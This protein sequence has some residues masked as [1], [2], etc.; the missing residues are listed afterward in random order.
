[1]VSS[2][3]YIGQTGLRAGQTGVRVASENISNV[4]TPGYHRRTPIFEPGRTNPYGDLRLGSGVR[5]VESRRVVEEALDRRVRSTIG[6][7]AASS[8]RSDVLNRANVFLGDLENAGVSVA[9]DDFFASLDLLAASPEDRVSRSN[10]IAAAQ[11]LTESVND[12]GRNL[13]VMRS[14]VDPEL[15]STVDRV[16]QLAGEIAELNRRIG[17]D[18]RISNDVLD[19]RAG[20][21]DELSTLVGTTVTP[22]RSGMW[23]VSLE[24]GYTLV[25]GDQAQPLS[26]LR[27]PD[28]FIQIEGRDAG[29]VRPLTER[30]RQGRVGGL[31]SARDDDLLA[32][33]Q[34]YDQFITSLVN[35]VNT[36]HAAG[37]GL[38][39]VGG[40]NLF[41]PPSA[42]DPAE[43]L[44]VDP[45]IIGN[46]DFIAAASDPARVPGDNRAALNLAE[47]R[48]SP[49]GG[50][51]EPPDA[52]R[53][54]L[55]EFGDRAFAAS[56]DADS[57]S[58]AADQ[59]T[60]LQ[61]Q[62]S[63]VSIDEEL[64]S[65]IQF[66]QLFS[67]AATVIQTADELTRDIIGLKR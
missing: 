30:I 51:Q 12:V 5:V 42:T 41:T 31:L 38:D 8:A 7:A 24:G 67:A 4:N 3:F 22:G 27:G 9:L 14:E 50:G 6:Q 23:N 1:M 28:G 40:R 10:V 47:L 17:E 60:T 61:Q 52:L 64:A 55:Q 35:E 54:V 53:Q 44:A 56:S 63:G 34:A 37:F 45:A 15:E 62:V 49:L 13:R 19:R 21:V 18:A 33:K 11:R 26:A 46:P 59:L 16:N 43:N 48:I 58:L 32:T 2:I 57:K 39:G 66:R 20:L 29:G 25:V 65:V 36:R